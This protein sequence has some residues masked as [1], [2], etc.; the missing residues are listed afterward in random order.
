ML[1]AYRNGKN[2]ISSK[3]WR[4]LEAAERDAGIR[5]PREQE[6]E[7]VRA[8]QAEAPEESYE[9]RDP[10]EALGWVNAQ[11]AALDLALKKLQNGSLDEEEQYSFRV[12]LKAAKDERG[13]AA[14]VRTLETARK[15][16]D[17][18]LTLRLVLN[19]LEGKGSQEPRP[20]A[21]DKTA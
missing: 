21:K 16:A 17:A 19:Q 8:I 2:P 1:F 10:D 15:N 5:S 18:A 13:R 12:T 14:F 6:W 7:E 4:K 9:R 20:K 3:A 11:T